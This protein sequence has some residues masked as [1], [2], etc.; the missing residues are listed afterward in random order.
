MNPDVFVTPRECFDSGDVTNKCVFIDSFLGDNP[1]FATTT[2]S[3]KITIFC[4]PFCNSVFGMI[5]ELLL[6]N[7]AEDAISAPS[8]ASNAKHN[9][10]ECNNNNIIGTSKNNTN[11]KFKYSSLL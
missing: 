1:E 2:L 3:L 6:C 5:D 11:N 4:S 9:Q 7:W 8:I 10:S